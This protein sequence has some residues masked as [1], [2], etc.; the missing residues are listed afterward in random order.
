[1]TE[2]AVAPFWVFS[3]PYGVAR[4]HRADCRHC[5]VGGH[6]QIKPKDGSSWSPFEDYVSAHAYAERV[7]GET[8]SRLT[9]D[10]RKCRP[11][12]PVRTLLRRIDGPNLEVGQIWS[13]TGQTSREIVR[14]IGAQDEM[15]LYKTGL[16][17]R[18]V[19]SKNFL[20]W[21]ETCSASL[22]IGDRR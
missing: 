7:R 18:R 16:I 17:S 10:C 13:A 14:L 2:G 11:G 12:S 3:G 4:V 20:L 19:L 22:E 21:I 8:R 6:G 1:V 15:V 5:V 9:V